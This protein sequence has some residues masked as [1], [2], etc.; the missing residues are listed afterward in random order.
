MKTSH[1][2]IL[3]AIIALICSACSADEPRPA[4]NTAAPT[5]TIKTRAPQAG[6]SEKEL[7]NT[8]WIALVD[9]SCT[10]NQIFERPSVKADGTVFEDLKMS[11][12]GVC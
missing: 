10:V 5:L 8:W 4:D 1:I 7:I 2:S 12:P 3:T 9:A 11:I 6:A